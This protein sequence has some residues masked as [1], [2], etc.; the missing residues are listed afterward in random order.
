MLSSFPWVT[1]T[2]YVA[3]ILLLLI[4]LFLMS[5]YYDGKNEVWKAFFYLVGMFV[6]I[7]GSSIL[8]VTVF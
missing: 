8:I 2:A 3:I 6:V 5:L 4:A 1:V 7:F